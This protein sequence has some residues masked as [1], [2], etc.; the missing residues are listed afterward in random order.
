MTMPE[1]TSVISRSSE[2][3]VGQV[4]LDRVVQPPLP[5]VIYAIP[6]KDPSRSTKE[7]DYD[8]ENTRD[9]DKKADGQE[10]TDDRGEHHHHPDSEGIVLGWCEHCVCWCALCYC[11]CLKKLLVRER[12]QTPVSMSPV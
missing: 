11:C 1:M 9:V 10:T 8:A 2:A 4:I 7:E 6:R 12:L 5:Q 3:P